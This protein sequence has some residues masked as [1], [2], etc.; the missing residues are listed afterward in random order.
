MHILHLDTSNDMRG[1]QYQLLLLMASLSRAGYDQT[2]LAGNALCERCNVESAS[3][4]TILRESHKCDL[5]HAHDARA[6]ALA[7]MITY[8]KP[9]VVARRVAFPLRTGF[10]SRWKYKRADHL[11]A[12]SRYVADV[13]EQCGV[14]G[15]KI[16]VIHDAVDDKI[17]QN[18][19]T[20]SDISGQEI[21]DRRFRVVAPNLEDPL[22][23]RDLALAACVQADMEPQC[24]DSLTEDL[25]RADAMLYLSMSEG[26]GSSMLI[27]MAM[28][29]PV[30]ASNVGGIPEIVIHEST[31]L[32]VNNDVNEIAFALGRLRDDHDLRQKITSTAQS[33]IRDKFSQERMKSLTTEIY[34]RVLKAQTGT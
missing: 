22:K 10:L 15:D 5:I 13:M 27:A 29:V 3:F 28:N 25:G 32:L 34:C 23:C 4:R 1:G 6:H 20:S 7:S 24:S 14:P 31:G 12:V 17:V 16:S 9:V 2:L 8:N 26:L 30:V 19:S 33:M 21:Q 11:I 18:Q